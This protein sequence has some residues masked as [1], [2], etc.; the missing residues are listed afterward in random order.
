M[1]LQRNGVAA[2]HISWVIPNDVWILRREGAGGPWSWGEALLK[3]DLDIHAAALA[4]EKKGVFD[5]IDTNVLPTKF[6]FPVVGK[7]EIK[8]LRKVKNVIRHGRVTSI[9]KGG[10]VS[11]TDGESL[12]FDDNHIF[13][14]CTSPGP[15]NGNT[16]TTPFPNDKEINLCFLYAPPVPIS[17]SSIAVLESR[18]RNGTLDVSFGRKLL[19][20]WNSKAD[21]EEITETDILQKLIGG[22]KLT[23]KDDAAAGGVD[24]VEPLKTLAF[25]M[26]I[27]DEN[28]MVAYKWL[29]SNRLSFF[30]IPGFKGNVYET[31]LSMMEK[32]K[33]LQLTKEEMKVLSLVADK[34]RPLKGK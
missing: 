4:L 3:H 25:F 9:D 2:E 7:D 15:F 33:V 14:H 5:R 8:L 10:K 19:Q 13:C 21:D 6:R 20:T 30:S 22:F 27:L 18:R 34:L 28:P 29:A 32:Q 24:Q 1:Y 23:A 16:I 31:V 11:F 12:V 26:A 17:M